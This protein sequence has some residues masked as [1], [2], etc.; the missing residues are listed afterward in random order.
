VENFTTQADK[1]MK[2]QR[3]RSTARIFSQKREKLN[4]FTQVF[5]CGKVLNLSCRTSKRRF[6]TKTER[7]QIWIYQRVFGKDFTAF[8][9]LCEKSGKPLA[10]FSLIVQGSKKKLSKRNAEYGATRPIPAPPFEKG[11][12]KLFQRGLCEQGALS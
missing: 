8:A 10:A 7:Q 1:S 12:R 5:R 6:S 3:F 9:R 2:N 11:G 4:F